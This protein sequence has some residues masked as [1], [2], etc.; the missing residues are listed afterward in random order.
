[1]KFKDVFIVFVYNIIV[2]AIWAWLAVFF[3]AWW[4]ALFG[5]LFISIPST[6]H[7]HYRVCDGCGAKSAPADSAE[8]AIRVAEK[9][10]WVH[11][12][13]GNRDYCPYCKNK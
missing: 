4:I 12:D 10:G 3:N 2:A 1:M 11:Y 7:R 6:I 9:A 5:I 8:E 13:E